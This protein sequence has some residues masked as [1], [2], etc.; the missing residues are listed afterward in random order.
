MV[1]R[2]LGRFTVMSEVQSANADEPIDVIVFG[3]LT[4]VTAHS[5]NA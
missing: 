5:Q 2:L 4:D 3:K 1:F